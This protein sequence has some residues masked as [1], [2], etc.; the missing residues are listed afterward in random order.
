MYLK[1]IYVLTSNSFRACAKIFPLYKSLKYYAFNAIARSQKFFEFK[2][3]ITC[4]HTL[5]LFPHLGCYTV[6]FQLRNL[7]LTKI[8]LCSEQFRKCTYLDYLRE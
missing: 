5:I 7:E 6:Q 3:S 4:T 2:F 1:T 8:F